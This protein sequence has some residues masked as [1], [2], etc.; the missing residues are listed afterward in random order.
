MSLVGPRPMVP[1]TYKKYPL[2]TQKKL[3][4]IRPGLTGV[5]SIFFRD[6]ECYLEGRDNPENSYEE[7][8]IPYKCQLEEWYVENANMVVYLKCIL[9]TA[10]TIVFP[11]I[12]IAN[13]ILKGIPKKPSNLYRK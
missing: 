8:I 9:L 6:A 12:E 1:N 2:S 11:K 10:W 13:K 5:G 7:E 4:L 3:N